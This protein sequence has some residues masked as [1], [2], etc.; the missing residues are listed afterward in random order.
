VADQWMSARASKRSDPGSRGSK[1]RG[2]HGK[3][4]VVARH[5]QNSSE[6]ETKKY[7]THNWCTKTE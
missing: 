3:V 5:T 6:A 2:V 4:G 7:V 1:E